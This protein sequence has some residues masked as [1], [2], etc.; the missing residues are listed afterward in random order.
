MYIYIY[1]I[2]I[3]YIYTYI[4]CVCIYIY[5]YA[6]KIMIVLSR[7]L[8]WHNHTL[9]IMHILTYYEILVSLIASNID[10]LTISE[11]KID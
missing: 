4:M 2:Y 5:I 11:A 8:S 3:L 7:K 6:T 10:I 1:I 9:F